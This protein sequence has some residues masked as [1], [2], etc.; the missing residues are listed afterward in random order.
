M[1]SRYYKNPA[2]HEKEVIAIIERNAKCKK[3]GQKA[4]K[5]ISYEKKELRC[6]NCG[7]IQS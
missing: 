1:D 4:I 7:H 2:Q 6:S 3:C 5:V